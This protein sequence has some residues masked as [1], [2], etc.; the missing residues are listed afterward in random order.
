MFFKQFVV[1]LAE[2]PHL[3]IPVVVSHMVLFQVLF[4]YMTLFLIVGALMKERIDAWGLAEDSRFAQII[5]LLSQE[6]KKLRRI[7]RD[8]CRLDNM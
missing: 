3:F 7:R 6:N 1:L 2:L 5:Y 8:R 4:L